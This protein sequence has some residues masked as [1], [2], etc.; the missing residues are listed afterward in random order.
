MKPIFYSYHI[1]TTRTRRPNG[2][3]R[4]KHS[5][6]EIGTELQPYLTNQKPTRT[7]ILYLY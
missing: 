5:E 7:D 2:E 6:P 1:S 4:I 3:N